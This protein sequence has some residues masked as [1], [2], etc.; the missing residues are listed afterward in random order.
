MSTV[1]Q[2]QPTTVARQDRGADHR[3]HDRQ[4]RQRESSRRRQSQS[5]RPQSEVEL[6]RLPVSQTD[7]RRSSVR[8]FLES[9][10]LVKSF[11]LLGFFVAAMHV[12]VFGL[13][14]ALAWPLQR[15]SVP[16]DAICVVCGLMLTYLSWDTFRDQVR[17][18]R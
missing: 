7:S 3:A 11:T 9:F 2:E 10:S 14:L 17:E 4:P 18:E 16:F 12:V 5:Q 15:A 13:D 6:V 8:L 1:L